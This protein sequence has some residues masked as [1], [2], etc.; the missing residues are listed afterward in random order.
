MSPSSHP[1]S[2]TDTHPPIRGG[3]CVSVGA[4][5]SASMHEQVRGLDKKEQ[6]ALLDLLLS[7]QLG[8]QEPRA[9]VTGGRDFETWC[10]CIMESVT[11][12]FPAGGAALATPANL[13]KSLALSSAWDPV[14]ALLDHK[15]VTSLTVPQHRRFLR[16]LADLLVAHTNNISNRTGA[17]FSARLLSNCAPALP[18]IFDN[19]YPGY[20]R[21]GLLG[22]LIGALTAA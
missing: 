8:A 10:L 14:K 21:A 17:P 5:K 6:K 15:A 20:M 11:A 12:R 16:L 18:S 7:M 19:A 9:T 22:V 3:V 4:S 13:R 2:Q 1:P